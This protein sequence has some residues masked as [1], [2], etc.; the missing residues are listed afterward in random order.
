MCIFKNKQNVIC[1]SLMSNIMQER[2]DETH[3]L[4]VLENIYLNVNT[5]RGNQ[6]FTY[7]CND[8]LSSHSP[9]TESEVISEPA[10][11][12]SP[13]LTVMM[14]RYLLFCCLYN[15][16]WLKLT[17]SLKPSAYGHLKQIAG[18]KR[19]ETAHPDYVNNSLPASN[20][21]LML[22]YEMLIVCCAICQNQWR[23]ALWDRQMKISFLLTLIPKGNMIIA[24]DR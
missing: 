22:W 10:F 21:M 14:L 3:I 13:G 23:A 11:K 18:G 6:G 19:A 2:K 1:Q 20:C 24:T 8:F 7:F 12:I 5:F 4:M 16:Q 17:Q 9:F 15:R